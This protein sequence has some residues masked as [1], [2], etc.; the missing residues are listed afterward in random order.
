M[1]ACE[2]HDRCGEVWRHSGPLPPLDTGN[3]GV[4]HSFIEAIGGPSA[5]HRTIHRVTPGTLAIGATARLFHPVQVRSLV[6]LGASVKAES[7]P[8]TAHASVAYY[9]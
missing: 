7:N 2:R 1:R 5:A 4:I 9:K 6:E 3:S 8:I